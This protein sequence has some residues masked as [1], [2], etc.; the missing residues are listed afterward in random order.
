MLLVLS[1]SVFLAYALL[2]ASVHFFSFSLLFRSFCRFIPSQR[3]TRTV[4]ECFQIGELIVYE[5][6]CCSSLANEPD[7]QRRASLEDA[8]Q[9]LSQ[10]FDTRVQGTGVFVVQLQ[11]ARPQN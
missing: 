10:D 5:L 9:R 1:F 6:T 11:G 8:L 2:L 4:S 3:V 7:E